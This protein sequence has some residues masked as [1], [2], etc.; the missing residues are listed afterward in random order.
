MTTK[1]EDAQQ[2]VHEAAQ[3]EAQA[4]IRNITDASSR[5]SVA[6]EAIR[7]VYGPRQN[8]YGPVVSCFDRC[9]H[10]MNAI[11][12]RYDS[13]MYNGKQV[14]LMM[15]SMKLARR[16]YKYK[17]DNNVDL[18]GYTDLMDV[19]DRITDPSIHPYTRMSMDNDARQAEKID[20]HVQAAQE[21]V[22]HFVVNTGKTKR[23]APAKKK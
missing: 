22:K 5:S 4:L 15:M 19:F 9:A 3:E 17:R 8:D 11:K 13:N 12:D 20:R 18:V 2:K 1:L 23:K 21:G 6:L 16:Q 7:A 10:I 14:A